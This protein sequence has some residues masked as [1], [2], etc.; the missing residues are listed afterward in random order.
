MM[1]L[2]EV[3][4]VHVWGTISATFG[5]V[6]KGQAMIVLEPEKDSDWLLAEHLKQCLKECGMVVDVTWDNHLG[7]VITVRTEKVGDLYRFLPI[8]GFTVENVSRNTLLR[9]PTRVA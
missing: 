5:R 1:E 2:A 6:I 7:E 9:L 4:L 3:T 8:I